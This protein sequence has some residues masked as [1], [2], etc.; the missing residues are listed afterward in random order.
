MSHDLQYTCIYLGL[1]A[2]GLVI[3]WIVTK[4]D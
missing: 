2:I 1:T 3:A 4:G